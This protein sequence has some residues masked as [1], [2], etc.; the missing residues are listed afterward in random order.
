[1]CTLE[2]LLDFDAAETQFQP[3]EHRFYDTLPYST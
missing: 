2:A 3:F 1:M